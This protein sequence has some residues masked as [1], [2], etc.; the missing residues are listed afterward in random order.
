MTKDIR[1]GDWVRFYQCGKIVI[2]VVQYIE[3][4]LYSSDL[5]IKTD[6]GCL[7]DYEVLEVRQRGE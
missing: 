5:K 6:I 1:E 2:G 7:R 3:K 4:D